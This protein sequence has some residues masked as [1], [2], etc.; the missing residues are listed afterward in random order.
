MS[1]E[2]SSRPKFLDIITKE[3]DLLRS[4]RRQQHILDMDTDYLGIAL[5]GGGIRSATINLGVLEVLN[6]CQVLEQADYLSSVS[7]GGYIAGYVT[8]NLR[9]DGRRAY[10]D[11]FLPPGTDWL[12]KHSFYLTPGRGRWLT[13]SRLRLVGALVASFLMNCIWIAALAG[14]VI[15]GAKFLL[16]YLFSSWPLEPVYLWFIQFVLCVILLI[17]AWNFFGHGLRRIRFWNSDFNST[18]AGILLAVFVVLGGLLLT[19][20]VQLLD[21]NALF[22][23]L[24]FHG[25]LIPDSVRPPDSSGT[26]GLL[27]S[28]L[29][30]GLAGL[31]ANP[32]ILTLHR[33]YRDRL[34][35]TFL[36]AAGRSGE[37]LKL[38]QIISG[39]ELYGPYPLI[40]TC[41]NLFNRKD[42]T[43]AG[44]RG[45]DYFLLSPLYCGSE[46]VGY[47]E[48]K[49]PLFRNMTLATAVAVSGAAVNPHMGTQSN[50]VAAF[51]LTLLNLRLGYWSLTPQAYSWFRW[52]TWWP[53]YHILELLS[54][55]DTTR[56]RVNLSDGGHIE[57]L[58]I[59]ELLRRGCRLIIA[60]DATADAAYAFS[61]LKN[62]V[63][64][65]R[66][67]LGL[68]IDFLQDPET[69][70][71][72]KPSRGFSRSHYVTARLT[73]L[74]GK[75]PEDRLYQRPGLL[76]YLKASM[77]AP[78]Q[79]PKDWG[80]SVSNSYRYKTYH[81]AFPH[82]STANQ[83]FDPDQWNAYYQL[84][85]F[86]AADLLQVAISENP[87][88]VGQCRFTRDELFRK[89]ENLV[90][91][92][93]L[94][95]HLAAWDKKMRE[96]QT[97]PREGKRGPNRSKDPAK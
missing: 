53:Y 7:G 11:M 37:G 86:M 19:R 36:Q 67:E 42:N 15:F 90:D 75:K 79:A 35:Q 64:R 25:P 84:G 22:T 39:T 12:R 45:S 59:Y 6:S 83:F 80:T 20:S 48:T 65:A 47:A 89:F 62:L 56:W 3:K 24:G 9:R 23:M 95:F 2:N 63:I 32:N 41:A 58:G 44:T 38:W 31:F 70:I 1:Q 74:E 73:D 14:I 82:E 43:F 94:E 85:R 51:S 88:D 27:I 30:L 81:P 13:L 87:S 72:P 60:V 29:T 93:I 69:F 76:I 52:L 8:S 26:K 97:A 46:L 21:G 77:R 61:D 16:H 17:L 54:W 4:K 5:S 78:R 92:S 33:F 50:N 28:L 18:S 55:N 57:N 34:R 40:N 68:A 91:P 10:K 96:M 66:N 49:N 71:R